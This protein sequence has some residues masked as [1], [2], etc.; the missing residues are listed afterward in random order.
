MTNI[1]NIN[2]NS[3]IIELFYWHGESNL[4]HKKAYCT[5]SLD[6]VSGDL[7]IM[8]FDRKEDYMSAN[9]VAENVYILSRDRHNIASMCNIDVHNIAKDKQNLTNSDTNENPSNFTIDYEMVYNHNKFGIRFDSRSSASEHNFYTEFDKLKKKYQFIEYYQSGNKKIEGS[10]TSSGYDG[11]CIEYYDNILSPIKYMGEFECG[12]YDGSG[13][14]FSQ[15]GHIRLVCNNICNGKPNGFG[16]LIIGKNK[17]I[18]L[19][20]MKDFNN[21]SSADDEYTSNIYLKIDP[22]YDEVLE[23]LTFESMNNE[24]RTLY[25]LREL[26]K[27]RQTMGKKIDKKIGYFGF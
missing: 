16:K 24:D 7:K 22:K 20:A 6:I 14:F 13:D 10:K 27:L 12:L 23:L 19:I 25:L 4:Y 1:N 5:L 3:Y 18:R 21:L 2:I 17:I 15:N 11:F 26:Q 9:I 8:S